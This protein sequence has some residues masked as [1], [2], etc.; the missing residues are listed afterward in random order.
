MATSEN[1]AQTPKK[2]ASISDLKFIKNRPTDRGRE[3]NESLSL[4]Y[5]ELNDNW[6]AIE[7]KLRTRVP[8]RHVWIAYRSWPDEDD[9]QGGKVRVCLGLVKFRG[10]WRICHGRYNDM[11]EHEPDSWK[12]IVDC[13][14]EERVDAV[15]HVG[16]LVAA[17]DAAAEK[18]KPIV[19]DAVAKLAKASENL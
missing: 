6:D 13:A 14:V 8:P 17:I 12:P 19:A 16:A 3:L 15:E 4:L 10:E 7:R 11:H 1:G 18:S 5:K 2:T 9:Q